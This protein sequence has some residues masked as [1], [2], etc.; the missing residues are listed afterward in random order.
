MVLTW[1]S[2]GGYSPTVAAG[3]E[4]E[5]SVLDQNPSKGSLRERLCLGSAQPRWVQQQVGLRVR[6]PGDSREAALPFLTKP[7]GHI[8]YIPF[9]NSKALG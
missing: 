8:G 5:A 9:M 6:N 2:S 3:R 7:Q 4:R 1:G